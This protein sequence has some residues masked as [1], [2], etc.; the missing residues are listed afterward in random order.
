[1]R[2]LIPDIAEV[3]ARKGRGN[4]ISVIFS[5]GSQRDLTFA[6]ERFVPEG[7]EQIITMPTKEF[8]DKIKFNSGA[9]WVDSFFYMTKSDIFEKGI[10]VKDP[11][12]E[13][14]KTRLANN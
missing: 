13:N 9:I 7:A 4:S 2:A 12:L 1:M 5:D 10:N 11:F 6:S 8:T 14:F 3:R